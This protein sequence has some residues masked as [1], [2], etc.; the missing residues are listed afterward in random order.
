[1]PRA[2]RALVAVGVVAAVALVVTAA[3][4]RQ[5]AAYAL[6]GLG[7]LLVLGGAASG[8]GAGSA[9]APPGM[10]REEMAVL[11]PD[12]RRRVGQQFQNVL[13]IAA[14]A[15]LIGLGVLLQLA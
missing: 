11:R 1:M 4:D 2:H 5:L 7:G 6:Y 3:I 12:M 13:L 10:E 15:A 9:Y 8:M 14:G